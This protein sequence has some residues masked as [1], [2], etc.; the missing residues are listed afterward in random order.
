MT[1]SFKFIKITAGLEGL[2]KSP[3]TNVSITTLVIVGPDV[4]AKIVEF[5]GNVGAS[6][7]SINPSVIVKVSEVPPRKPVADNNEAVELTVISTD[8]ELALSTDAISEAAK[9]FAFV[10]SIFHVNFDQ[11]ILSIAIAL[12]DNLSKSWPLSVNILADSL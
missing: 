10:P 5:T 1:S 9:L 3:E 4:S 2:I 8:N 12:A 7:P 11:S 6:S